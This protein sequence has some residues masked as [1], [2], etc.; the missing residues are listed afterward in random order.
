MMKTKLTTF[1]PAAALLLVCLSGCG[2]D[3]NTGT[4]TATGTGTT[5]GTGATGTNTAAD[6]YTDNGFGTS[7]DTNNGYG[8]NIG[9]GQEPNASGLN[10]TYADSDYQHS[11][12]TGADRLTAD[13]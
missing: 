5:T 7:Y 6:Y 2:A 11:G 9:M 10:S 1:L 12:V 3:A 8:A 4:G 13:M